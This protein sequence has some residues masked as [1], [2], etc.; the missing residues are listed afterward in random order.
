[1][2]KCSQ[3]GIKYPEKLLAPIMTTKGTSVDVCGI[4][5]LNLSNF[6]LGVRRTK[7]NGEIAEQMR[8]DAIE[9]RK[10]NKNK[11]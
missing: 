3:C 7:F 9:F 10:K 8:L 1:M 11:I 4:C 5:G 2:K 6:I